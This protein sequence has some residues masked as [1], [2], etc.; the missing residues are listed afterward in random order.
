MTFGSD[1]I[2]TNQ[3][4]N[5]LAVTETKVGRRLLKITY[6]G[7]E[8]KHLGKRQRID[9]SEQITR[10]KWT[11]AKHVGRTRDDRRTAHVTTWKLY[12]GKTGETIDNWTGTGIVP[13]GRGQHET[14]LSGDTSL[15]H[16]PN[17]RQ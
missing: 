2:L 7:E 16:S 11:L 12:E 17:H 4:K 8:N 3:A 6:M 13:A 5:K 10:R 14:G 9:V 1:M 15:W